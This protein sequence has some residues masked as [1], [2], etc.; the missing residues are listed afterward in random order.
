[1]KKRTLSS[2]APPGSNVKKEWRG[3]IIGILA[4]ALISLLF[5]QRWQLAVRYSLSCYEYSVAHNTAFEDPVASFADLTGG[6]F[7]GFWFVIIVMAVMAALHFRLH[8]AGSKSIYLLRRLPDKR[9]LVRRTIG[10]PLLGTALSLLT[11]AVLLL[12]YYL[13]YKYATPA[14]LLPL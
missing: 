13:V 3:T 4:S 9:E 6:V 12:L 5:F 11:A 14:A 7:A 1:M 2:L 8:F 10:M